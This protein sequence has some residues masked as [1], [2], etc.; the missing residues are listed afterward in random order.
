[1]RKVTGHLFSSVDGVVSS[2][3]AWQFDAFGPEEGHLMGAAISP[4]TDVILGRRLYEEW[5]DYWPGSDDPYF[6]PYI[7]GT[8]KHVATRT[9]AGPLAWEGSQVIEGDLHDF[10]RGLR[11][12][13]GG[14][15]SVNGITVIKDLFLA[16]LLDELTLTIHPV[17][18]GSGRRLFDDSDDLTRLVLLRGQVTSVGNSV[19][20][21]ALRPDGQA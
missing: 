8:P 4:V 21:Y 20:T 18:A 9:L 15:I 19:V 12:G 14:D 13:E 10:V 3:N 6:A 7:N 16:G 11:E 17:V 2:P 5:A 1:M